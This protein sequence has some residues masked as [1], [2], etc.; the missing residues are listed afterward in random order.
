LDNG[1]SGKKTISLSNDEDEFYIVVSSVP[2]QFSGNQN[3]N[4][5]ISLVE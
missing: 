1:L 2:E 4:Y 3:Y 5:S